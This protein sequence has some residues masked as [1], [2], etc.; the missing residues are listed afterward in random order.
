MLAGDPIIGMNS[1]ETGAVMGLG[2]SGL[3][4]LLLLEKL[5]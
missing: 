1:D 2:H 4:S 3:F 5:L